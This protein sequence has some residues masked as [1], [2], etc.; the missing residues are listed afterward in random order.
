MQDNTDLLSRLTE[1]KDALPY[2]VA[3]LPYDLQVK[4]GYDYSEVIFYC[5]FNGRKC[6]KF[7]FDI[8]YDLMEKQSE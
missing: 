2:M 3:Q 5:T 6:G 7:Y 8:S 1:V 4:M